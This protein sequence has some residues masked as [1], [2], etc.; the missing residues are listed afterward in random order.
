MAQ[1]GQ[2]P[3]F[4][5]FASSILFIN[6]SSTC[7]ASIPVGDGVGE[8]DPWRK[9]PM[10]IRFNGSRQKYIVPTILAPG[11]IMA[12]GLWYLGWTGPT[13]TKQCHGYEAQ[14]SVGFNEAWQ[15]YFIAARLQQ[16]PQAGTGQLLEYCY[17]QVISLDRSNA[18]LAIGHTPYEHEMAITLSTL[19][20][21][22]LS[23]PVLS[24]CLVQHGCQECAYAAAKYA[25]PLMS[26]SAEVCSQ[27]D[28]IERLL[29]KRMAA[30]RGTDIH[31][32]CGQQAIDRWCD[33]SPDHNARCRVYKTHNLPR[34][35]PDRKSVV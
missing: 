13:S 9:M 20:H 34:E 28:L 19:A 18:S 6:A 5:F 16:I 4:G 29:V 10:P 17:D 32:I 27:T 15:P 2:L 21:V 24:A 14:A 3:V 25:D 30:G 12:L 1:L 35:V 8:P 23:K 11:C 7:W 26:A 33:K 22:Q 31:K